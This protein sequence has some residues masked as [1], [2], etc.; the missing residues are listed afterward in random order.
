[1]R[2][3]KACAGLILGVMSISVFA[4]K[5]AVTSSLAPDDLQGF[6]D[7]PQ[8]IQKLISAALALTDDNL[9]YLYGGNTP[10]KG[11][12]DCSG[13]IQYIL[14][15]Q[16][17]TGIPRQADGLFHW[18]QKRHTFIPAHNTY[19]HHASVFQHLRPGD[20]L[21]WNGTYNIK[22]DASHVMLY[23]GIEKKTG[24][25]VMFG[26]SDGRRHNG[27]KITGVSVF[28]FKLPRKGKKAKFL[29]FGAIPTLHE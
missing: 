20:L 11:G 9:T 14:K 17:S 10:D 2:H 18:T 16:L 19:S 26:A 13:T 22:R 3:F 6:E 29:G 25:P 23:L 4:L 5:P 1:M 8:S 28:D 27:K 7:Y 21:F 15:Q 24:K 12:M